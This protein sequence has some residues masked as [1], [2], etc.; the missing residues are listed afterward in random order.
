MSRLG[1]WTL[2]LATVM[3]LAAVLA[4][5]AP[6]TAPTPTPT[7]PPAPAPTVAPKA[8]EATPTAVPKPP[9][10]TPTSAV[11]TKPTGK[12]I[13]IGSMQPLAGGLAVAGKQAQ[14]GYELAAE[15][16]NK[17]GGVNGSP[18]ELVTYD[19][20]GDPKEAVTVFRK[21]VLEDKVV[22]VVGPFSS[23]EF[24]VTGGLAN[25][26]KV[27][28]FSQA[29]QWGA[30]AKNRPW[31][32]QSNTQSPLWWPAGVEAFKK[33]YPEVKKV[34]LARDV[35]YAAT[36]YEGKELLPKLLKEAGLEVVGTAEWETF[37]QDWAA[38]A[39]KIKDQGAAGLFGTGVY[40]DASGLFKELERLGYKPKL[41]I[42]PM[43]MHASVLWAVPKFIEGAIIPY[44]VDWTRPD[45]R[46]Q[47]MVSRWQ[48]KVAADATIPKPPAGA[49]NWYP[50]HEVANYDN[51]MA[52]AEIM[53]KA[54]ITGD[55]PVEQTR[56]KIR[57]G[58]ETLKDYP[59]LVG[60]ITVLPSGDVEWSTPVF[61][62]EGGVPKALK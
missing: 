61:V 40:M 9:A 11:P 2:A 18:V 57:Q 41:A 3:V 5:C 54:G 21:L 29:V 25:E 59:G 35:K 17:A 24:N 39:T 13:K 30:A 44:W 20:K 43:F 1:K 56:E 37:T 47:D 34:T 42:S 52:L 4:A 50:S 27:P 36:D 7:K 8:A 53:R 10:A 45:P 32:F 58:Y 60:K 14:I 22:A 33:K 23:S 12:P 38:I 19:T 51:M 48:A 15:D 62:V 26:L 55:T 16:L 49:Y 6:A 31:A 28:N 46:L